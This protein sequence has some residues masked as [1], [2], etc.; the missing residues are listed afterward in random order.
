MALAG[1]VTRTDTGSSVTGTPSSGTPGQA[2]YVGNQPLTAFGDLRVAE[3]SPIF[4]ASFE[5]TVT[6]TEIGTISTT[7]SGTV[8][9][10]DAMCVVG[11]GTTT[12][13]DADWESAHNL[14]YRAG[15]G[16]LAR[17][18]AKFTT[19]VA[20][21]EQSVGLADEDGSTEKHKNGYAVG[22]S[23]TDFGFFRWVNDTLAFT[24]CTEWDD[25]LDGTG[26]SG[27]T[28]DPTKLNVFFINFQYLGAG[29]IDLWVES[30]ITGEVFRVHRIKYAG[31]NTVPSTYMPNFHFDISTHN[32]ATTEDMV[33]STASCAYFVEGKSP[34]TEI[35]QPHHTSERQTKTSI[36]TETAL[37]TIRNK[38]T[39]ASKPNFID[40]S[41]EGVAVSIEAGAANNLGTARLLKNATLG[42]T[43]S[44]SDINTTDSICD[45]DTSGTTV[46]GGKTI[47]VFELAGKNDRVGG[48]ITSFDFIMSPG[49]TVTLAVESVASATFK[50]SLLWKELF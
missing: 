50:G 30:N 33:V 15:L 11:T 7:G 38:S 21:T 40:I 10:A 14:K 48:D 6:N 9:Q 13:S 4:Q 25:P 12:G 37:F 45:I 19:G 46:T 34:F 20:G 18:T 5:Y 2:V 16:G 24:P 44:Y 49:D 36:T 28:I 32:G 17:F 42:G 22:Y 43:P 41:L 29:A 1:G 26:G 39:Y 3:L 27:M 35:H 8:T 23:G 31:L 47:A